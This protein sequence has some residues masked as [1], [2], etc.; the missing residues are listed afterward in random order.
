MD[1]SHKDK[2][3]SHQ[4][5]SELPNELIEEQTKKIPNL[6]FLGL[7]LASLVGS[8]MLERYVQKKVWGPTVGIWGSA[9]LIL[10][11]YNKVVKLEEELLRTKVNL[12]H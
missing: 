9:F 1:I 6:F 12:M 8:V 5:K 11:L 10:G 4:Y 7:G 3:L 2:K